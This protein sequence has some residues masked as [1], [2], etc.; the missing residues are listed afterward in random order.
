VVCLAA[1]VGLAPF[2]IVDTSQE[3]RRYEDIPEFTRRDVEDIV[4]RGN[5]AELCYVAISVSMFSTDF[6]WAQSI[7]LLLASHIDVT[8]RGNAVL[9]LGH[10]ARR[11]GRL[12]LNVVG[13][14]Y[15]AAIH[16]PEDYVRSQAE[17]GLDD[18]VHFLA[19]DSNWPGR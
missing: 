10:L 18:I 16:D 8:V 12:D 15:Q 13:P 7:C 19:L 2:G 5:P 14:V 11:F 4:S 1:S 9:S 17:S 6:D 3:R